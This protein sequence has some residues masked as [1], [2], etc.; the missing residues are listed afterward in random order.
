MLEFSNPIMTKDDEF[1]DNYI[2]MKVMRQ[3]H[4]IAILMQLSLPCVD[5][6]Y[7]VI[8]SLEIIS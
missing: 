5:A 1:T 2:I 3:V 7:I 6:S 4:V 8:L